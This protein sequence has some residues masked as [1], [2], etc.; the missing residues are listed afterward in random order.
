MYDSIGD[1]LTNFDLDSACVAFDGEKVY[2]AVLY[3]CLAAWQVYA[4]PRAIR[5]LTFRVNV[6][7]CTKG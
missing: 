7:D 5:A 4:L 2:P 6:V 3:S 1:I